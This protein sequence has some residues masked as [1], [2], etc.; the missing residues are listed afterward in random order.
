[1]ATWLPIV[2][3]MTKR[4]ASLPV[5]SHMK[6]SKALVVGSSWKTSSARVVAE[7]AS[8]MREVGV[9]IVSPALL[10]G[11]PLFAEGGGYGEM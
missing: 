3:D 7:M 2:P 5:R 8:S 10:L 4:E 6:D 1:M 11:G 9:V